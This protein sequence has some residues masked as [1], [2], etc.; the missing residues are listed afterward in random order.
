MS[1]KVD[2]GNWHDSIGTSAE[3]SRNREAPNKHIKGSKKYK[4]MI[5]K[6]TK[7]IDDHGNMPFTFSKPAKR[8]KHREDI[9]FLCDSC[10]HISFVSKYRVGQVC[11]GCR[12][13]VSVNAT[14]TYHTEE[15][16]DIALR[17]LSSSD[18]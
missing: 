17:E 15:E 13:Y 11:R 6:D 8:T 14:N 5:A 3:N 7:R 1:K 9:Y 4:E 10:Q 18:D 16:L 12:S 2:F